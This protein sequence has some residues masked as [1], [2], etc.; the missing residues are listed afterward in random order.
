MED[1]PVTRPQTSQ[2]KTT[3]T[4]LGHTDMY[5]RFELLSLYQAIQ[6]DKRLKIQNFWDH[7]LT[8]AWKFNSGMVF[9]FLQNHKIHQNY[10]KYGQR[11]T[12][13]V[14]NGAFSI[15]E[16]R[17]KCKL[18]A[19]QNRKIFRSKRDEVTGG[20]RKLHNVELHK[21]PLGRPR[22]KWECN[23]KMHLLAP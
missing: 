15:Q 16:H 13:V 12:V 10:M 18:L 4:K 1:R 7:I 2:N 5:T 3:P 9:S 11:H 22:R 19:N 17:E 8:G 21:R 6:N 20:W 14:T 23:I